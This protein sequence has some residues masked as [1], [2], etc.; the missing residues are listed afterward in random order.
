MAESVLRA[1]RVLG[2]R[3]ARNA[4]ADFAMALFLD[5]WLHDFT[6]DEV[7]RELHRR[8]NRVRQIQ[9][10]GFYSDTPPR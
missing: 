1:E 8:I 4:D 3:Y 9:S 6:P 10:H 7:E 2:E 5:A